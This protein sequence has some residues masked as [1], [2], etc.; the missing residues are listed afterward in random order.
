MAEST[1]GCALLDI[2]PTRPTS[3]LASNE[4]FFESLRSFRLA[5][6]STTSDLNANTEKTFDTGCNDIHLEMLGVWKES[7]FK[8]IYGLPE[9]LLGLLSQTIRLANEQELLHRDTSV[10]LDIVLSLSKRTKILEHQVLSWKADL[11]SPGFGEAN[12][13][14]INAD[15]TKASATYYPSLAVHQGLILFYYRR[16]HNMNALILQDTVRKVLGF[17]KKSEVSGMANEQGR[18]SLL[19]PVFIAACE[20]LD[21]DLQTNLLDWITSTGESTSIQAFTAAAD[22]VQRVWNMRQEMMDYTIS[23]FNVLD[24][25]RCPIIAI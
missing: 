14:E 2:C 8:E 5:D 11:G 18:A 22:V 9:S 12:S 21:P 16:M 20:A 7:L 19:W 23:W 25:D 13:S 24:H 1:C 10:N 6:D 3:R 4:T 15:P 17:V